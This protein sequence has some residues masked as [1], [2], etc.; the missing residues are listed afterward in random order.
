MGIIEDQHPL[1]QGLKL[2]SRKTYSFLSIIADQHPL[3]QGLKHKLADNYDA[4]KEVLQT[5]IH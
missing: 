4:V 1:K 3:K 2:N 5:N